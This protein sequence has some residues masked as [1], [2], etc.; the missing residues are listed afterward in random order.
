M[1]HVMS[2]VLSYQYSN[3]TSAIQYGQQALMT[4]SISEEW[5]A[6]SSTYIKEWQRVEQL[7][8]LP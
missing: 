6:P 2:A 4:Q 5:C 3:P 8:E 7:Y 1:D